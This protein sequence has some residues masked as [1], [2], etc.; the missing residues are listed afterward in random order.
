VPTA[1]GSIR[2]AIATVTMKIWLTSLQLLLVVWTTVA[3]R[4]VLLVDRGDS[5]G[6][7]NNKAD[8]F[9]TSDGRS[10]DPGTEQTKMPWQVAEELVDAIKEFGNISCN[11]TS[12]IHKYI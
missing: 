6:S 2:V 5:L 11:T 7:L 10:G 1:T 3:D 12:F 8:A 9:D 4:D